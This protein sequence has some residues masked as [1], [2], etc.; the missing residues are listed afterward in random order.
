MVRSQPKPAATAARLFGAEAL[1]QNTRKR[2]SAA[3]HRTVC[4]LLV[5]VLSIAFFAPHSAAQKVPA[6]KPV[7]P[8]TGLE[9]VA[10]AGEPELRVDGVPFFVHAAQFD[11]FRI[12]ADL[13]FR[14]LDRYKELGINTIDLRIPWN[15]HEIRDA[16]FDFDGHTNPRRNLRGLLELIAEKHF[17]LI[18]RPGPL[19]GDHW[20]NAGY[21]PWLLR[22][23]DYKMDESAIQMGLAPLDA[24]LATLD[25]NSAARDWL[26]NEI[27]MTYARRWMTAVARELAPFN[28]RDTIRLSVPGEREGDTQAVDVNGPLLFVVLEDAVVIRAGSDT[29][30]VSRYLSEL[31]RGLERGGL[32]AASL[33]I[34]PKI[35]AGGFPTVSTTIEGEDAKLVGLT[36]EWFFKPSEGLPASVSASNSSTALRDLARLGTRDA[37]SLSFLAASLARQPDFPP[38]LSNLATTAVAPAGDVRAPQQAS[39]NMLLA[40]RVLLGSGLR[41][42]TYTPLQD[43]LTPAGWGT[44]SAA[45]YFR[46]DAALD[47]AGNPEQLAGGVVRNGRLIAAWG[48]ML[49]SSHPRADFGIV[50]L[51]APLAATSS[52][53]EA[54]LASLSRSLGQIF[55]IAELAGY[56]PELLNPAAQP[57]ERLLRDNVVLL[58][59]LEGNEKSFSLS[60]KA[61]SALVEFVR[62]GGVL[63]YFPARPAGSLLEILWKAAPSESAAHPERK[64]WTFERGRVIESSNDFYSWVSLAEDLTRNHEEGESSAA[65]EKFS[66][67]LG[68]A[69]ASRYL[70]R[71][72]ASKNNSELFI[73]QVIANEESASPARLHACAEQQLCAAALV[74]VTNLSADQPADESLEIS[75][76]RARA[77]G[78][79]KATIPLDVTVPAHESLLL[80]VHAP[81]C[82][83]AV[84][85]R[86]GDEVVISGAELLA[87][88]RDGKTLELTF[89]APARATVRLRL[90]SQPTKIEIGE[91]FRVENQWKQETGEVEFTLLRGAAPDYRRVVQVH[92]HYTPHVVEKLDPA[93]KRPQQ[94]EHDVFDSVRLP[95][96][97][98]A[99]IPTGPPLILTGPGGGHLT[100]SSWNRSD[101]IHSVDFNLDGAFRG[102]SSARIFPGEQM[103]SRLRFQPT[104]GPGGGDPAA[105]AGTDGLLQGELQLRASHEHA[106]VPV[107]FVPANEAG[108]AHYQYDF[109]RD[110]APEWVLES[111]RLR[112][113]V[114]PADA[115]RALALVD[116]SNADDLITLG[117]AFHD[118][119]APESTELATMPASADFAFN[120]AYAAKWVEEKQGTGLRLDYSEREDS[121]AGLHVEKTLRLAAPETLETS[122]RVSLGATPLEPA[123]ISG[124]ARVFI[125]G[126]SV[127]VTATEELS[128]RFCWQSGS[129]P[130]LQMAASGAAKPAPGSHCENF[131]ASGAPIVI[132]AEITRLEIQ[133]SGRSSLIVEWSGVHATIVPRT[134]SAQVDFVLPA[135]QPGAAPSEF[136]LR[137]TVGDLGR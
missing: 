62:R 84:E 92:L 117:G 28:S 43:T 70:Q 118:L 116:K 49:A 120:R 125:S 2:K 46:W 41:G 72:G 8:P 85:E 22:Y 91:N 100:I 57:V 98:D 136:T 124:T 107:A 114:S 61:Q 56:T 67:L 123:N 42:F 33:V 77:A 50:D 81:L 99:S 132:P 108:N 27:H 89:Y 34:V 11:Y 3:P 5:T 29:T 45:R 16:D 48:A 68:D 66:A 14:S 101:N 121:R 44:L 87:A 71:T 105:L 21:P 63:V 109:D 6:Q 58:P 94:S 59:A 10:N 1:P 134:F 69:G 75:D 95:L 130:A 15:W 106:S 110:G 35:T 122:Y 128:T 127:P 131:S 55:R 4:S 7:A 97:S 76:P 133:T 103:F 30:E 74:S 9:I 47:L 86:C 65:I 96:A 19:I 102:S 119:M 93:K 135:L 64:E 36:G 60:E 18:V 38:L 79:S 25:G 137:Y 126:L 80:P 82:S 90:E 23:S 37:A 53:N 31:R 88:E 115:G 129:S 20:R 113:I 52:A 26:S 39:E 111:E 112:V 104:H 40:S 13:W 83:A 78:A 24:E 54:S 17:R 32:D 51:R 12:P 73:S